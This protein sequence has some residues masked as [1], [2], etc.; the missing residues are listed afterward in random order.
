[1]SDAP[2]SQ[3]RTAAIPSIERSGPHG[4]PTEMGNRDRTGGI[5]RTAA[6][7]FSVQGISWA[8]SFI[9]IL[10]VP[11]YLG[12]RD[13]G[14][15]AT[16]TAIVTISTRIA[17][18]GTSKYITRE[19]ARDRSQAQPL[20]MNAVAGRVVVSASICFV[21]I[22]GAMVA[23]SSPLVVALLLIITV[24][25]VAGS[26]VDALYA[27]LQ[28]D[29]TMGRSAAAGSVLALIG[30]VSIA[31]L[32]IMGGGI[33]PYV[34]LSSAAMV[35]TMAVTAVIFAQRFGWDWH[36]SP[37][38]VTA[39]GVAGFP[40]L[41]WDLG[42]MVYGSVDL[43]LVPM[44]TDV[45]TA[46]QYA[47]A[48]RLASIPIFF[49][50]VVT[51]AVF[52]ALSASVVNDFSWFRRVLTRAAVLT[53]AGTLPLS[54]GLMILAPQ[55]A[56]DIGGGHQFARSVPLIVILSIHIPLAAVDAIVGSAIFALNRQKRLAVIAWIAAVLNPLANL[57][58]IPL[59]SHLWG[60]GAIGAALMTV[61]TEV[62]I[63]I[64]VFRMVSGCLLGRELLSG[65][66]RATVAAA[67]M[68]VPV[69]AVS[70]IAGLAPAIAVGG[71]VYIGVALVLR[72]G[73]FDELVRM[74]RAFGTSA[75]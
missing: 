71:G 52:P 3:L 20:T 32:L 61:A 64:C 58:A 27:A 26:I 63:G 15:L 34:L 16:L 24:G 53:Y 49:A 45:A 40:F 48:Y 6:A 47:F 41:V 75:A 12:A 22:L 31:V 73:S 29:Q 4:V 7:L 57:A 60:N 66:V 18:L 44:L 70:K 38:A 30:Q 42:L 65:A 56:H 36:C 9:G 10:L 67:A 17:G 35:C 72:V 13:L 50:T 14:L 43:L 59:A 69:M 25:S 62:L 37:R 5:V 68:I 55:F 1:M 39:L 28:G 2:Q 21:T 8:A 23:G 46:G 11:R 51:A 33:L 19:V 54:V 74:R